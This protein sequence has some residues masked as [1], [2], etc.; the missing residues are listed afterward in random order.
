MALA[1]VDDRES[2]LWAPIV[3]HPDPHDQGGVEWREQPADLTAF[4]E[5]RDHLGLPPLFDAQHDAIRALLG[6]D[7][8]AVFAERS[9]DDLRNQLAVLLWGKGSGKDYLCSVLVCYLVHI[10]LCLRDPQLWFGFGPGEPI[11]VLNVAY[12]ADQ[13]KFVF[14][15]KLKARVQGWRWLYER[16]NVYEGGRAQ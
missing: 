14:F 2:E 1:P 7:P 10:L 3:G 4:V 15:A 16:F 5:S 8:R 13:A 11:D 12:N 6:D 9:G